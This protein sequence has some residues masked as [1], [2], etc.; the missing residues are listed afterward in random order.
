MTA[1]PQRPDSAHSPKS[2]DTESTYITIDGER[3]TIGGDP[4]T[5]GKTLTA[6][7]DTGEGAVAIHS[8]SWTGLSS[9]REKAHA[10]RT[11]VP[12]AMASIDALIAHYEIL[13]GTGGPPLEEREKLLKSLRSLHQALGHLLDTAADEKWEQY[14]E[15]LIVDAGRWLERVKASVRND[16]LPFAIAGLSEVIFGVL[17]FPGAGIMTATAVAGAKN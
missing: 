14:G 9:P 15:G 7:P 5:I 3:L 11:M 4:I 16:P 12:S 13:G 17:G 1:P 10:V 8:A 2:A 6:R